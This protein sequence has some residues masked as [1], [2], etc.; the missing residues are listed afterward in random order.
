MTKGNEKR[1]SIAGYEI[2]DRI[3]QG[4]MGTVYRARQ[5]SMDRTVALKILPSDLAGNPEYVKRFTQEAHAAG[6][7]DHVNI[8]RALDVGN[9][10]SHYYFAMEYVEGK[11][12]ADRLQQ[13]KPFTQ[14]E[15]FEI[16]EQI[17]L[18]LE[19]AR[20]RGIVHRDIKPGNVL[21]TH[22]G[23]AKLADFGLARPTSVVDNSENR[24]AQGTPLYMSPEQA[25]AD[26]VIDS[27][28]DIYS[29]GATLYHLL[30]GEPPF[31]GKTDAETL[32]MHVAQQP[33]PAHE[34]NPEVS[35]TLS[36][37]IE[38]MLQKDPGNRYETPA[39]LVKSLR[40]ARQAIKFETQF[41]STASSHTATRKILSMA[42]IILLIGIALG[43]AAI[44]VPKVRKELQTMFGI[45]DNKVHRTPTPTSFAKKES[46][47]PAEQAPVA[48]EIKPTHETELTY[49]QKQTNALRSIRERAEALAIEGYVNEALAEL[50]SM[51][52]ELVDEHAN[53]N[54][55]ALRTRLIG[56]ATTAMRR[57]MARAEQ[58]VVD[59]MPDEAAE[60]I[61]KWKRNTPQSMHKYARNAE[62]RTKEAIALIR[63]QE[64][65]A[66]SSLYQSRQVE[67]YN[68]IG[69]RR[70]EEALAISDAAAEDKEIAAIHSLVERDRQ[71]IEHV[72]D[73][74]RSVESNSALIIGKIVTIGNLSG[75]VT[76]VSN[77]TI[78]FESQTAEMGLKI[79][80]LPAAEVLRLSKPEEEY[81][82]KNWYIGGAVLLWTEK[83]EEAGEQLL[84]DATGS[85]FGMR[86]VRQKFADLS[87]VHA[88][89]KAQAVYDKIKEDAEKGNWEL[90][91]RSIDG[92]LEEFKNHPIIRRHKD[93]LLVLKHR[94]RL[95]GKTME[96]YFHG[97]IKYFDFQTIGI[98]YDFSTIDQFKDWTWDCPRKADSTSA[99]FSEGAVTIACSQNRGMH[100]AR[101][102]GAPMFVLPLFLEPD[103]WSIQAEVIFEGSG[104]PHAGLVL[105]TGAGRGIV[106]G[107]TPSDSDKLMVSAKGSTKTDFVYES[108][109]SR[110]TERHTAI[111]IR[112]NNE[113]YM[114][115][116]KPKLTAR[117][118]ALLD[119]VDT[120]DRFKFVGF[121][122]CT[123]YD[124]H[125]TLTIKEVRLKGVPN[126]KWFKH[127][128]PKQKK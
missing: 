128:E 56:K 68:L 84:Q 18:A 117:R 63:K 31:Q 73:L 111:R 47:D 29:L 19:H 2:L 14:E 123:K 109:N 23:V 93:N 20:Q 122:T 96:D 125:C 105:W 41:P 11:S 58:L 3:G 25:R 118:W 71:Y 12:A 124:E 94:S 53:E 40:S 42:V 28:S 36:V 4:G 83:D 98:T 72:R 112:A 6:K 108:R 35:K 116:Y 86:A 120:E 66:V 100:N 54:L 1:V 16:G 106:C 70:F 121:T 79:S 97:S 89:I 17:A 76:D 61:A 85:G 37:V 110:T 87:R 48:P 7:L 46:P 50:E 115:F 8:V 88:E 126:P 67:I 51:P 57:E 33:I 104:K 38:R 77:G 60:L 101:R 30:C 91:D 75:K 34:R 15:I 119:K 69:K 99:R 81:K 82:M 10:G 52:Q 55:D 59:G 65:D 80:N 92:L 24:R 44:A 26:R 107:L 13:E 43:A 22:A 5:M 45:S 27:R 49:R 103:K 62:A 90:V 95:S 114:F 64:Q 78:H 39:Q 32:R 21:I 74:F 9:A 113:K 102:S 127:N